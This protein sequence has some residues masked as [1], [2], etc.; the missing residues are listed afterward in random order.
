[1]ILLTLLLLPLPGPLPQDAAGTAP[2]SS[3]L[4]LETLDLSAVE[5]DWG[6]AQAARS[7]D[8]RPLCIG[9]RTFAHGLGTHAEGE[10][11]IDLHEAALEFLAMAGVDDEVG[12]RGSVVFSVWV[13]GQESFRTPTLHGGDAPQLIAVDLRGARRLVLVLEDGGDG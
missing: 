13:D 3:V 6:R 4:R 5:Q 7:V 9:G 1:M 8:G 10:L 12:K 2:P 11:E